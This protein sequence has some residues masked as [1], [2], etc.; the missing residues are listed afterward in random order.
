MSEQTKGAVAGSSSRRL[1]NAPFKTD[2]DYA[3]MRL[4]PRYRLRRLAMFRASIG[5]APP[6]RPDVQPDWQIA[7]CD[8]RDN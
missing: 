1:L 2:L 6:V 5:A 3:V 8:L 4:I 7:S